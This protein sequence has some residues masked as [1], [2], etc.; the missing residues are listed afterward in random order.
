MNW[1]AI[2]PARLFCICQSGYDI[3]FVLIYN[4]DIIKDT[5]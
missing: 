3:I 1:C 2:K 5:H 4:T